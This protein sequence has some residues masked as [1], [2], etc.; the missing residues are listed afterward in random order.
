MPVLAVWRIM[1]LHW[2][3]LTHCSP[4]HYPP[5]LSF[6]YLGCS[7]S[8]FLT[9]AWISSVKYFCSILFTLTLE[10]FDICYWVYYWH[11]ILIFITF[12]QFFGI[13]F[14]GNFLTLSWWPE[15]CLGDF[16]CHIILSEAIY[17]LTTN[18]VIVVELTG[19]KSW[20]WVIYLNDLFIFLLNRTNRT[21]WICFLYEKTITSWFLD[22]VK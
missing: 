9:R 1:Q 3:M 2:V 20:K 19:S 12:E 8:I 14:F 7:R 22:V 15:I 10:L 17:E 16:C 6:I 21:K 13:G 4:L 5:P 18:D 11:F